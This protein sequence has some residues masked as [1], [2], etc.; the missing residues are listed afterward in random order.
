VILDI[1]LPGLDGWDVLT[2]L[3]ED[4]ATA[5]IPVVVVSIL[6]ERDTGYALGAAEYLIKPVGREALLGALGRC[7][8]P[9]PHQRTAIVIDDDPRQLELV[10]ATLGPQGWTVLSA[11]SGADGVALAQAAHPAVVLVDLLMP[12]LD[13]FQ[14]VEALRADA[15]LADVP[16]VV[17]TSKEMTPADHA[18]LN[19]RIS[20]LARKG[21]LS[22]AEMVE[23]V[24]RVAR[25]PAGAQ[26]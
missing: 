4:P 5:A 2:R 22:P 3:K 6:D 12:E 20:H 10:E 21:T 18:R 13:G 23:V 15:A 9:P 19:G 26:P 16:I 11:A 24:D 17:L 1:V 8:A 14:V 7:A 25:V